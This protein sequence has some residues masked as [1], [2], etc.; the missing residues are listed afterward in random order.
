MATVFSNPP[1]KGQPAR[2]WHLER[3]QIL[4]AR[5]PVFN[6]PLTELEGCLKEVAWYGDGH[7]FGRLTVRE[8]A[9]HSRRIQQASF[10]RP[11]ILSSEG[12]IMD[13]FHRLA[14]AY[15]EGLESIQAVQFTEDPAPDRLSTW[16]DWHDA[17]LRD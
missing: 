8:V 15:L 17:T 6:K 7:H 9:E 5:L 2:I 1:R 4:A 11:I 12:W 3:V 13:G 14:R 16:H 10:D